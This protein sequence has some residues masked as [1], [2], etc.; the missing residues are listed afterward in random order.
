MPFV[1]ESDRRQRM[2][3]RPEPIEAAIDPTFGETF[4]AAF[5]Y[6]VDEE[7]SISGGLNKE[8]LNQRRRALRDLI[9]QGEVDLSNYTDRRGRVDYDRL[10]RQYDSIKSTETIAQERREILR[11]RRE[12]NQDV[13]ER[14]NGFAQF[15]GMVSAFSIDPVNLATLPVSTAAVAARSLSWVGKGLAV[16]KREAA[17]NV[18]A[19]LAIQP[20]V[21]QHK[22]DIESPYSWQDAVTN[23]GLAAA[24]GAALGF[25]TG[26]VSGYLRTVADRA[27]PFLE[28]REKEIALRSLRENARFIDES[29][30]VTANRFLNE[31]YANFV[32]NKY[33]SLGELRTKAKTRLESELTQAKAQ[34][35]PMTRMIAD[36]GGLNEGAW[37]AAGFTSEDISMLRAARKNL[38]K[39]KPLLRRA[40]GLTPEDLVQR[41]AES[42]Y[43][44]DGAVSTNRALDIVRTAA[45]NPDMPS[46]AQAAT[47]VAELEETIARIDV[48]D[49][50]TLEAIF[51]EAQ[52][53]ELEADLERLRQRE[54]IREKMN[55]PSKTPEK[56]ELPE[57]EP[58]EIATAN[59]R[60]RDVL[61]RVGLAD[62]YD[63]DMNAYARLER[64][65]V[66]DPETGR[67]VN[68]DDVI[69]ELDEQINGLN[70]V[71]RCTIGA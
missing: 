66:F 62:E 16:A 40:G 69:E 10:S 2:R 31:E 11:Q 26:G 4:F 53:A 21:Y 61:N 25:V 51:K 3:L 8:G 17:L 46:N 38:P 54:I 43:I 12:Q 58:V 48:D 42:G 30:P 20:L 71:L 41:L 19:E 39:N 27:D 22:S 44:A 32:E 34:Q 33:A 70:E 14:G 7:I 1:H 35:M 63:Q 68:A 52:K 56:F 28:G 55:Q 15:L 59:D 65:Q 49:D 67:M 5:Q 24:G 13:M 29:R 18:A 45:R 37:R 23:I 60:Q 64:K 36:A 57:R 47:R 6:T 9:D 50:E